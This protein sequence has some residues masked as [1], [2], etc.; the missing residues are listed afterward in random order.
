MAKPEP[1]KVPANP[2]FPLHDALRHDLQSALARERAVPVI[3]Q[4]LNTEC[5]KA[6]WHDAVKARIMQML[7]SGNY[8]TR[9]EVVRAIVREAR[10]LPEEEEEEKEEEDGFG[11]MKDKGRVDDAGNGTEGFGGG[12]VPIDIKIPKKATMEGVKVVRDALEKVVEIEPEKG[13][14]D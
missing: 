5:Q 7:K 1:T 3:L 11:G 6:G 10:G 4:A 2:D 13:F 8:E 14:W 9:Q 12:E